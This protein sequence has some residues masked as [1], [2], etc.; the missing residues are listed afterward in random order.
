MSS[1]LTRLPRVRPRADAVG[2]MVLG[3]ALMV[4]GPVLGRREAIAVGVFLLVLVLA[5]LAMTLVE[6]ALT[7]RAWERSW[8]GLAA[9]RAEGLHG[10]HPR[11]TPLTLTA[12]TRADVPAGRAG[13]EVHLPEPLRPDDGPSPRSRRLRRL[14]R[15]ARAGGWTPLRGD[16]LDLLPRWR[17]RYRLDAVRC[18]VT[19]PFG[20]WTAR[21]RIAVPQEAEL[22][23]GPERH[24]LPADLDRVLVAQ[25]ADA[26]GYR[27]TQ[28]PD[29]VG[30]REHTAGDSLHRVHWGATARVGQLMVRAEEPEDRAPVQLVVDRSLGT[31]DRRTH[32]GQGGHE[33][34]TDDGLEAVVATAAEIESSLRAET[35]VHVDIVD[36]TGD[37]FDPAEAW[38]DIYGVA[39][40]EDAPWTLRRDAVDGEAVMVLAVVGSSTPHPPAGPARRAAVVLVTAEAAADAEAWSAAGWTVLESLEGDRR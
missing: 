32:V 21:Q 16:A 9:P 40:G 34:A 37:R 12:H 23:V 11:L 8:I 2:L 30:L 29:D 19:G 18:R 26:T 6:L 13:L 17:G 7:R 15:T 24:R 5:A 36:H 25:V 33:V 38:T 14:W 10:L 4:L 27:R 3:V 31:G 35:D 20:L 28:R 39:A 22:P 1:P